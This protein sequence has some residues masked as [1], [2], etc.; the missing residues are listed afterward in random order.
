M[1]GDKVGLIFTEN[2][3]AKE[4]L[5]QM[6]LSFDKFA[7]HRGGVNVHKIQSSEHSRLVFTSDGIGVGVIVGVVRAT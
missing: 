3:S 1:K 4:C 7:P 5:I 6:Y 2:I